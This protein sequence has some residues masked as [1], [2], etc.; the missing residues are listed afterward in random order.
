[1]IPQVRSKIAERLI[2]ELG[3]LLAE[4]AQLLGVSTPAIFKILHGI[5]QERRR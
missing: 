2:E 1:L 4:G 3:M 5:A